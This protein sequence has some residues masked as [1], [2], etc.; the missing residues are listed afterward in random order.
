[1]RFGIIAAM[2]DFVPV[3]KAVDI[4]AGTGTVIDADGVE[5]A[6]F[7]TEGVFHALENACASGGSIG[8]G[9]LRGHVVTCPLDGETYD[10][11]SGIS[12]ISDA[13]FV[14]HFD[15]RLNN[16]GE[17]LVRLEP[18]EDEDDQL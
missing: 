3:C 2:A 8:E 13:I 15:V 10:V 1:M 14:R 9:E 7:N 16:R 17:V 5:I 11:R 18:T 6:V 4:P 12:P